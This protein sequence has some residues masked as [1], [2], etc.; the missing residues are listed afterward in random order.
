MANNENITGM[1]IKEVLIG[2]QRNNG[3]FEKTDREGKPI[4]ERGR[5]VYVDYD[6][7][8][9]F[10]ASFYSDYSDY[11]RGVYCAG[12]VPGSAKNPTIKATKVK[13]EVFEEIF[14]IELVDFLA[15][16]EEKY[17]YHPCNVMYG[18]NDRGD[19]VPVQVIILDQDIY[20]LV[21]APAAPELKDGQNLAE[22]V[23]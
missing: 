7:V 20:S 10:T 9:I 15:D 14:G 13:A 4:L 3:S 6:S 18:M 22:V 16:F 21:Q 11:D 1:K 8:T 5:R 17:I 12:F 23:D 2:V 19:P